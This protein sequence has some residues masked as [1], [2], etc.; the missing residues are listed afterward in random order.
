MSKPHFSYSLADSSYVEIA[1]LTGKQK[2]FE[3]V[4]KLFKK[5]LKAKNYKI[6]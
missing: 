1:F 3:Y 5:V 2:N 4:Q 6:F